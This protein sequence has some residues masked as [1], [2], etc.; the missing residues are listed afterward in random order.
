MHMIFAT[1]LIMRYP[2]PPTKPPMPGF[3]SELQISVPGL[4]TGLPTTYAFVLLVVLPALVGLVGIA[5]SHQRLRPSAIENP[6]LEWYVVG[7]AAAAAV[8]GA[9]GGGCFA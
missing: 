4:P 5:L 3:P 6:L 8:G 1:L 9:G 2:T 7:R